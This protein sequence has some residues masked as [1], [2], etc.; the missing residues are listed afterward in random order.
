MMSFGSGDVWL[1]R[2]EVLMHED[3]SGA[4]PPSLCS[5]VLQSEHMPGKHTHSKGC[6]LLQDRALH[7]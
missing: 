1:V 5:T 4:E 6:L 3:T 7:T 2:L